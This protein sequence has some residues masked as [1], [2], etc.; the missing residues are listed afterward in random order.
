MVFKAADLIGGFSKSSTIDGL[1]KIFME[2]NPGY[3]GLKS[4]FQR[5]EWMYKFPFM[6]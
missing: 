6:P 2:V 1:E 3:Y 4:E 5:H